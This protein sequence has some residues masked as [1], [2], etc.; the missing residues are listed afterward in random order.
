MR[1][2][3]IDMYQLI[4]SY[5]YIY[6]YAVGYTYIYIDIYVYRRMYMHIRRW[7]DCLHQGLKRQAR[8][9]QSSPW[10]CGC[11]GL[12]SHITCM[13]MY[14]CIWRKYSILLG[15]RSVYRV[16]MFFV[17]SSSCIY[18]D[19]LKP[20][21]PSSL[22][23]LLPPSVLSPITIPFPPSCTHHPPKRTLNS[24]STLEFHPSYSVYV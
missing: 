14:I 4:V 3:Y 11:A 8:E 12:Y 2:L 6:P 22:L 18:G 21:P 17:E 24:V 5:S 23:H 20:S 19:D 16:E 9:T 7:V 1:V 10:L 13:Y 15:P